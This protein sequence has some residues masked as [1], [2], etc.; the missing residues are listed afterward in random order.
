MK[1][2][3]CD[4]GLDPKQSLT[5]CAIRFVNATKFSSIRQSVRVNRRSVNGSCSCD[6]NSYENYHGE[7]CIQK[8][9]FKDMKNNNL[10]RNIPLT[11]A[12]DLNRELKNIIFFCKILHKRS[13]CNYLAN[14]CVLFFYDLDENGPCYP[15]Y[16]QQQPMNQISLDDVSSGISEYDGG[17]KLKPFLFFRNSKGDLLEKSIDFSYE[18]TNVSLTVDLMFKADHQDDLFSSC[19]GKQHDKFHNY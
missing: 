1:R 7:Y 6:E 17:E 5:F 13:Y 19:L 10:Y 14:L 15:F 9:L 4:K 8:E 16:R 11:Q 12:L 18:I 3:I 2:P